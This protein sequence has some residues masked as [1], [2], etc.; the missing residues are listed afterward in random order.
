[1]TA[2]KDSTKIVTPIDPPPSQVGAR[3][4]ANPAAISTEQLA[5]MLGMPAET[6]RRHVE[7]G[8]PTAS[9][10]TINLIH[11]AAWLIK[12]HGELDNNNGD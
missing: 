5:R 12:R 6:I 8:A 3:G 11:Y 7:D 9:D 4:A 2:R 1:M 10:G